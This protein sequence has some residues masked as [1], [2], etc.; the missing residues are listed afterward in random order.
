MPDISLVGNPI[1][2]TK[3][4]GKVVADGV[5]HGRVSMPTEFSAYH[6]DYDV[7]PAIEAQSLATKDK[8]MLDDVTIKA[9]PTYE[10]SNTSGTTFIIGGKL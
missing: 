5:L 7:T 2:I 9:I 3:I 10:V 4:R 1:T 6:G 8:R